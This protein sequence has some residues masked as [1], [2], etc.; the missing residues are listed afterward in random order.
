MYLFN[1]FKVE[2]EIRDIYSDIL[3]ILDKHL[4]VRATSEESKAYFYK[5]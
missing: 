4:I 5:M 2:K 3:N 1:E